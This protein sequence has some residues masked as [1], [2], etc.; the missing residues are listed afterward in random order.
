MKVFVEEQRFSSYVFIGL[1]VSFCVVTF[2]P[3][4]EIDTF[5]DKDFSIIL[6]KFLGSIVVLLVGILF[7][8]LK[9][10]TRIDEKGIHYQFLPFHFSEKSILWGEIEQC[11]VRKYSPIMEY[12]GWGIRG[13]SK[14]NKAYNTKGNIGLQ[15]ILKNGH[16]LLIGSQLQTELEQV[17][18]NYKSK[19]NHE[20]I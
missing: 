18:K 1:F 14:K 12:G 15:L 13:I 4:K 11:Y 5:I 2:V 7:L 3:L 10:K 20:R 19:L 9:L 17:I 16:K 8:F 6:L